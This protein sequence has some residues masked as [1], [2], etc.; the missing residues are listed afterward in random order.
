MK[1]ISGALS[2]N[3]VQQFWANSGKIEEEI[4]HEIVTYRQ[5]S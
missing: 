3:Y 2:F 1:V 4:L 5:F